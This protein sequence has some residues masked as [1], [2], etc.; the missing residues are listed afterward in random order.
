MKPS[1][2]TAAIAGIW[3]SIGMMPFDAWLEHAKFTSVLTYNLTILSFA[4]VFFLLPTVFFVLGANAGRFGPVWV[5]DPKERAEYWGVVK[6]M[7]V[8][9]ASAGMTGILISA[10]MSNFTFTQAP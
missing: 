2:R 3:T 8:G 9:F 10:A 5:L 4:A 1:N 6:R 7:F